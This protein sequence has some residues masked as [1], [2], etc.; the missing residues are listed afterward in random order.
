MKWS[1]PTRFPLGLPAGSV[2]AVVILILTIGTVASVLAT[3]SASIATG[4]L[5]AGPV[6]LLAILGPIVTQYAAD[7]RSSPPSGDGKNGGE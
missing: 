6:A 2:R 7:R 4:A 3:L 5:P 1:S